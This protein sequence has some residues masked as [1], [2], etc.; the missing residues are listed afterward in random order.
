MI[1]S[2]RK[3]AETRKEAVRRQFREHSERLNP[4]PFIQVLNS[5]GLPKKP[6]RHTSLKV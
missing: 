6:A 2:K 4:S 5:R 3:P 1:T